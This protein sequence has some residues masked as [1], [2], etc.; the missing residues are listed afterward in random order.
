MV[1][2]TRK[3]VHIPPWMLNR[4]GPTQVFQLT[5]FIWHPLLLLASQCS[6]KSPPSHPLPRPARPTEP[7]INRFW[8]EV[9][10]DPEP[11]WQPMCGTRRIHARIYRG[12]DARAHLAV[13]EFQVCPVL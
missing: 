13:V 10:C 5:P 4:R 7:A 11:G 3:G 1:D 6:L 9:C 8:P 2:K 12:L